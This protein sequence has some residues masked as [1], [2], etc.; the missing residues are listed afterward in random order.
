MIQPLKEETA[1]KNKETH[2][3]SSR[4]AEILFTNPRNGRKDMKHQVRTS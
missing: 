1:Q 4:T 2:G 3:T